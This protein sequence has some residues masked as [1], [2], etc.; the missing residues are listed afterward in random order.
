ML[1]R[2]QW[3]SNVDEHM[4]R[5]D[6]KGQEGAGT[7]I[8]VYVTDSGEQKRP[9]EGLKSH[10]KVETVTRDTA[11]DVKTGTGEQSERARERR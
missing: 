4:R 8:E 7:I 1:Q 11:Q 2:E 5:E 3:Q 6:M 10:T 9:D